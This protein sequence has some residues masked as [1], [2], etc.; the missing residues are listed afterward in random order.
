[1]PQDVLQDRPV[2]P[3][4]IL[5][6][7]HVIVCIIIE[8]GISDNAGGWKWFPMFW[9]DFPFVFVLVKIA[10]FIPNVWAYTVFGTLCWYGVSVVFRYY[11]RKLVLDK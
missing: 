4:L 5:P 8:F 10:H 3:V 7:L 6:A 9:I 1:M 11:Y 2:S